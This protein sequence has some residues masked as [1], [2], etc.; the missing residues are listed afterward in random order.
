MTPSDIPN[1]TVLT[2]FFHAD[3]RKV[4]GQKLKENVILAITFDRWQG[5]KIADDKKKIYYC[6]DVWQLNFR[7]WGK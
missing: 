7:F 1:G 4:N 2:A 6:T 3:A 5:Q